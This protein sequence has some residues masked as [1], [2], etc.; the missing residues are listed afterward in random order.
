[1]D[2]WIDGWIIYVKMNRWI[3]GLMDELNGW[4]NYIYINI[5]MN[6]WK[7]IWNNEWMDGYLD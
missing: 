2:I 7:D 4:M 1:M 5:N 3:F 6:G